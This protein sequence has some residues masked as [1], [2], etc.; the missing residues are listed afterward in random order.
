MTPCPTET[1]KWDY[2]NNEMDPA[3]AEAFALHL[4]VCPVCRA[5]MDG[6]RM[7]VSELRSL[8]KPEASAAL[9][10]TAKSALA[11]AAGPAPAE[12]F[13]YSRWF[14]LATG[15]ALFLS[16]LVLA[17]VFPVR[18]PTESINAFFR[19]PADF[20]VSESARELI[21]KIVV[22]L[23]LLLIP[24]ILENVRF[25]LRRKHKNPPPRVRLFSI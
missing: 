12:R 15:G 11:R 6:L 1:M 20:L 14:S 7:T 4:G 19:I 3:A 25:L 24:S 13:R 16:V 22:L 18:I 10:A 2:L 8:P 5:E 21:G 23:P 17:V 9:A